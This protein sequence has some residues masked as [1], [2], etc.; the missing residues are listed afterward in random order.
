MDFYHGLQ[1]YK[2][3]TINEDLGENNNA[4][5]NLNA[6]SNNIKDNSEDSKEMSIDEISESD[7]VKLNKKSRLLSE[8]VPNKHSSNIQVDDTRLYGG[9]FTSQGNLYYCSSQDLIGIYNSTNPYKMKKIKTVSALD[10]N[11]TIASMDTTSDE[12]YLVYSSLSPYLHIVDLKTLWKFHQKICLSNADGGWQGYGFHFGVFCWKFSGDGNELVWVTNS[13]QII[14]YDL[15]QHIKVWNIFDTHDNDINTVCFANRNNSNILFTGSDDRIIKV[16]DRRIMDGNSPI[17]WF[18]GHREGLTHIDSR[19]DERYLASN[20]KDQTLKLWDLRKMNELHDLQNLESLSV[21]KNFDYRWMD[22]VPED[23]SKH[24]LDN[25]IMTFE[26]H[27]VLQTLIRWYFS[28]IE[29]TSQRYLY[30]GSA[31]G[32]IYVFDILTG[33]NKTCIPNQSGQCIRDISWH[34]KVP[35]IASTSFDG[36]IDVFS[37]EHWMKYPTLTDKKRRKRRV[38]NTYGMNLYGGRRGFYVY[39]QDDDNSEEDEEYSN[40]FE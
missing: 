7:V 10:V 1:N 21:M 39:N 31:D 19:G 15:N 8:L 34:P 33:E 12:E 13:A 37:L 40:D 6:M 32:C 22:Y 25:S 2:R 27:K 29:T 9:R 36:S 16:W 26:G 11:W 35:V 5:Q 24:E 23:D 28:P 4:V 38:Q 14:V 3:T 18:I 30:S 20:G 17:G